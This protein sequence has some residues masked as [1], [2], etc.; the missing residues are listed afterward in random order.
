MNMYCITLRSKWGEAYNVTLPGNSIEEVLLHIVL[1]T[2][3]QLGSYSV[4]EVSA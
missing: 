3:W 4:L 1:D 2:E